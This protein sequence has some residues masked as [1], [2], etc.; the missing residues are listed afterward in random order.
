ML[1][2][3]CFSTSQQA[4]RADHYFLNSSWLEFRKSLEEEG[5]YYLSYMYLSM[6][7]NIGY[8]LEVALYLSF[9][10]NKYYKLEVGVLQ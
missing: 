5:V 3:I 4:R 9:N 1:S 8:K 6:V 2:V 10:G 7:I